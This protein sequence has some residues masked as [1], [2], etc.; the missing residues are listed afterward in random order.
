MGPTGYWDDSPWGVCNSLAA[1]SDSQC[2][3]LQAVS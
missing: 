3:G 2:M 1:F